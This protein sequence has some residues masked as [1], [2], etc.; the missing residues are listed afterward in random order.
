MN[1][2]NLYALLKISNPQRNIGNSVLQSIVL[3]TVYCTYICVV[4]L[5]Q[6]KIEPFK[7]ESGR[8]R[9][10][11]GLLPR[12]LSLYSICTYDIIIIIDN[13][14][15]ILPFPFPFPLDPWLELKLRVPATMSSLSLSE[16]VE[17]PHSGKY[18]QPV[19]L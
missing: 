19:G 12:L 16:T 17:T 9:K 8:N 4:H 10:G 2:R 6:I 14:T 15:F 7:G 13:S 1:I 11:S 3:C 5:D 18:E